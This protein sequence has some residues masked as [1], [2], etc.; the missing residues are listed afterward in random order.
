MG[1]FRDVSLFCNCVVDPGFGGSSGTIQGLLAQERSSSF[2]CEYRKYDKSEQNEV[3]FDR[4]DPIGIFP[5]KEYFGPHSLGYRDRRGKDIVCEVIESLKA[6]RHPREKGKG[7][8]RNSGGSEGVVRKKA[9]RHDQLHLQRRWH[10]GYQDQRA[11]SQV[12]KYIYDT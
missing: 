11:H 12:T 9:D 5:F 3:R 6:T 10:P 4:Q 2:R 8:R 1:G 7:D